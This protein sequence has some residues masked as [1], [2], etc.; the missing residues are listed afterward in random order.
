MLNRIFVMILPRVS[1]LQEHGKQVPSDQ[2][3]SETIK[4][5]KVSYIL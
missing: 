4:G 1:I 3:D 2:K 5:Q